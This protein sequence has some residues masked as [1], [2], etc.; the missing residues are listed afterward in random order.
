[1]GNSDADRIF[2]ALSQSPEGRMTD[3][4]IHREVFKNHGGKRK[5][6]AL[7]ELE[8]LGRVRREKGESTGGRSPTVW[9]LAS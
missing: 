8:R 5:T 7:A 9:A 4:D 6:A 3:E 2:E 1:V